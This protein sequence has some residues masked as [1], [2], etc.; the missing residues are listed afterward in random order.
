MPVDD[1]IKLVLVFSVVV[2]PMLAF[3]ARFA[4]KP[5]VDAIVRLKEGGMLPGD[6]P[7]S[8]GAEVRQMR[9]ELHDLHQELAQTRHE[10]ARLNEAESFNLALRE[11]SP[12]ARLPA[13]E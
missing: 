11:A 12:S 13:A 5:I 2:L 6:S 8:V 4:L 7:A 3:T 1:I 10:V 9:A